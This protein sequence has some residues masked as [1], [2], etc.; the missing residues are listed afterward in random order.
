M[1]PGRL[2]VAVHPHPGLP[3]GEVAPAHRTAAE[4]AAALLGDL[5]HVVEPVDP[6]VFDPELLAGTSVVFAADWAA[7]VPE[8]PPLETMDPWMRTLIEMGNMVRAPDYVAAMHALQ[9]RSRQVV[10][11]FDRFDLLLTPT[12]AQPPPRVGEYRDVRVDQVARMFALTPFTAMWNTT[13]QPA[14]SIPWGLDDD[15]LPV[16]VQLVGRPAAEA[17]LVRV[18]AQV[19]E[20]RPWAGLRPPV[21]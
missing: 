11:F 13:G 16:G 1:P 2:R 15:G 12:V 3:A 14:V 10:G 6:P 7:R 20:A 17:T 8:L 4:E 21:S 18:S 9:D 5:G 19:E